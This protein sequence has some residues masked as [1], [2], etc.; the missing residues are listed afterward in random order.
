MIYPYVVMGSVE[1]GASFSDDP[2]L[3]LVREGIAYAVEELSIHAGRFLGVRVSLRMEGFCQLYVLVEY[4][5][6]RRDLLCR[7]LIVDEREPF[8]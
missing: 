5:E 3:V 6:F 7:I 1:M 2:L 8:P 4:G